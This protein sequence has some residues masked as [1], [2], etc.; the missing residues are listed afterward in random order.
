MSARSFKAVYESREFGGCRIEG[1]PMAGNPSPLFFKS[2]QEAVA[3]KL[4]EAMKNQ[5]TERDKDYVTKLGK[6]KEASKLFK[7]YSHQLFMFFFHHQSTRIFFSSVSKEKIKDGQQRP[8]EERALFWTWTQDTF[9][10]L[11]RSYER[12]QKYYLLL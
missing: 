11:T 7:V 4:A 1:V 6:E 3:F 9:K 5:G 8:V 12:H 10:N 2:A